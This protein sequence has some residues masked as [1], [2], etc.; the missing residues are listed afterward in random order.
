MAL[1]S[2]VDEALKQFVGQSGFA[3][4]GGVVTDLD[5]TAVHEEHGRIYIRQ[6]GQLISSNNLRVSSSNI[7]S[8]NRRAASFIKPAGFLISS[9]PSITRKAISSSA[10]VP[11]CR[12]SIRLSKNNGRKARRVKSACRHR[13]FW[14]SATKLSGISL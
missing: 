3:A 12:A 8:A 13:R 2:E 10:S 11:N 9:S 1:S 4:R 14:K 5:G 7:I 6:R